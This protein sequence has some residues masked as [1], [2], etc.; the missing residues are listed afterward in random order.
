MLLFRAIGNR[1]VR[2]DELEEMSRFGVGSL[3][4]PRDPDFI[5]S[6]GRTIVPTGFQWETGVPGALCQLYR[7]TFVSCLLNVGRWFATGGPTTWNSLMLSRLPEL[8]A[9]LF[10]QSYPKCPCSNRSRDAVATV[11]VLV[12]PKTVVL[13]KLFTSIVPL[14]TKQRNW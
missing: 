8:K 14:F 4:R 11:L 10:R 6:Y 9:R 13:G 2:W 1:D 3:G 12:L 5:A 7:H